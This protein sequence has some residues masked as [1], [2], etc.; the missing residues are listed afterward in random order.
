MFCKLRSFHK[1]VLYDESLTGC[2][3]SIRGGITIGKGSVV[4]AGSVVTRVCPA[5][6][7]QW[8]QVNVSADDA[9]RMFRLSQSS[10]VTLLASSGEYI[11]T[12]LTCDG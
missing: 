9:P 5:T 8:R 10:P 11:R 7:C 2:S 12:G 1:F 3:F 4:G 6:P